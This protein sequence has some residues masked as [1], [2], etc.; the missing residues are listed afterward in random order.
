MPHKP[1]DH[2]KWA[3]AKKE[4]EAKYRKGK[5]RQPKQELKLKDSLK[6]ILMTT[7]T[8]SEDIAGSICHDTQKNMSRADF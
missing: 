4:R 1:E 6:A 5:N 8:F 3:D 2:S 7:C